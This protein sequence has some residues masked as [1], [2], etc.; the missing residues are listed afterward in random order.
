MQANGKLKSRIVERNAIGSSLS[1]NAKMWLKKSDN[2]FSEEEIDDYLNK[3]SIDNSIDC[4]PDDVKN[5][6]VI[7]DCYVEISL[8]NESIQEL[9]DD[10]VKTVEEIKVKQADYK[11]TLD[12]KIWWQDVTDTESY[13]LA[14]LNGY[15]SAI[16]KPYREY[17]E[18]LDMFKNKNNKVEEEDLSWM[19]DLMD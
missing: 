14:N 18:S 13:F 3:I 12:N 4:L 10:I 15:S 1:S 5:K 19:K 7:K 16:H 8:D 9:L 2:K 11:V 6:F 17:L